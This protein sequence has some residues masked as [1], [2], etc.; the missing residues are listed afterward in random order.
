MLIQV[1]MVKYFAAADPFASE[2]KVVHNVSELIT[3]RA[4]LLTRVCSKPYESSSS[5]IL[6]KG[7]G[8]S[9]KIAKKHTTLHYVT[10]SFAL[11]SRVHIWIGI[12]SNRLPLECCHSSL[13]RSLWR[14]VDQNPLNLFWRSSPVSN[15]K[16]S[17]SFGVVFCM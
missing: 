15:E 3:G 16:G 10:T 8:K 5:I 12:G 6:L 1:T 2:Y 14:L 13:S 17:S 7:H 11:M 4:I 9:V